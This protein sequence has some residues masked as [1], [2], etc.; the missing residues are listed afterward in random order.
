VRIEDGVEQQMTCLVRA[1][2]YG[3]ACQEG[4]N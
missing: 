4:W 2:P 3:S 1:E